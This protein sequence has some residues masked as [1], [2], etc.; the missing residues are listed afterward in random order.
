M[1]QTKIGYKNME[2]GQIVLGKPIE[3]WT[4]PDYL[5]ALFDKIFE[6]FERV[7]GNVHQKKYKEGENKTGMPKIKIRRYYWG[8]DPKEALK[9]NFEYKDVKLYWYKYRNRS[10]TINTFK[11]ERQWVKWTDEVLKYIRKFDKNR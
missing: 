10:M 6:E 9:A 3:E 8:E 1:K 11:T 5:E 4:V 7:Y 2:L